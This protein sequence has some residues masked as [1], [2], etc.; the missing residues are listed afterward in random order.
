MTGLDVAIFLVNCLFHLQA[1]AFCMLV[2]ILVLVQVYGNSVSTPLSYDSIS[3]MKIYC[4]PFN[5]GVCNF[6]KCTYQYTVSF[7]LCHPI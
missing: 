4:G 6:I 1:A 3:G 5:V 2:Q 7:G